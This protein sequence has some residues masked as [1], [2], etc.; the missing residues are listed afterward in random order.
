MIVNL[1][2]GSL[3][4]LCTES[5]AVLRM[6]EQTCVDVR[7]PCTLMRKLCRAS[8]SISTKILL[9]IFSINIE[10]IAILFYMWI[11]ELYGGFIKILDRY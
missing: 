1:S 10:N 5:M 3:F 11:R 7:F 2:A 8:V 9:S 4:A 6:W